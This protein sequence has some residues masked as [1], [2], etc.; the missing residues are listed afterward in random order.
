MNWNV[1]LLLNYWQQ[2][3]ESSIK[4]ILYWI[5]HKLQLYDKQ[6]SEVAIWLWVTISEQPNRMCF[7]FSLCIT[8]FVNFNHI[9]AQHTQCN[10][11]MSQIII[12]KLFTVNVNIREDP[13]YWVTLKHIRCKVW[14]KLN[15]KKSNH[16]TSHQHMR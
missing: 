4:W 5:L 16:K 2:L 6:S 14:A 1:F 7:T 12:A 3:G 11:G 13:L 15:C 9:I 10:I 8:M